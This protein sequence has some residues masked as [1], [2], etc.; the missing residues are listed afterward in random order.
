VYTLE[1]SHGHG[2]KGGDG[3]D[4]HKGKKLKVTF[5]ELMAE[6]VKMR[7]T[8]IASRP[9]SVKLSRSPPR[10]KSKK[11]NRQGNKSHTSMPC[12]PM[13]MITS[14]SYEPSPTSFHPY[15]SWGWNGTWAQPLSYY[16]P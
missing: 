10:R 14:I 2:A 3:R 8:R 9:S 16:A 13:V 15:S 11:W 12:P 1:S 4:K 6:Y 5:N 7:D